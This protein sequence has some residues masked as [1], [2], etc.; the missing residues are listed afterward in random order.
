LIKL[1][2]VGAVAFSVHKRENLFHA[3][4]RVPPLHFCVPEIWECWRL[5]LAFAVGQ[6]IVGL[7]LCENAWQ[8]SWIQ[9]VFVS[10]VWINSCR[11]D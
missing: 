11:K 10:F 5:F 3:R 9:A 4:R 8:F 6:L 7:L 1:S 2:H